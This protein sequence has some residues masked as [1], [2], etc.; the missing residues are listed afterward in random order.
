MED[1][2][3]FELI[4]I[5][6]YSFRVGSLVLIIVILISAR[7]L[8]WLISTLLKKRLRPL[9]SVD[10]GRRYA[11]TNIAKYFIYTLAVMLVLETAG[12]N[13]TVLI[14]G[15]T[16]LFV[17][18]GFGLQ[19]TFNDFISG[20]ILLFEGSLEIDH[21][22]E[23]KGVVGRVT[24][25]G[26]RTSTIRTR[27][28]VNIIVPN[29][30]FVSDN[31]VNWSHQNELTRFRLAISVAYGS[32]VRRVKETLLS[33]AKL[34]SDVHSNPAPLVFFQ[35]FAD[36]GLDFE[37]LFWTRKT[38]LAEKI[39]SDLRFDIDREFRALEI[40]IPFPQRDVHLKGGPKN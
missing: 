12:V 22:V 21:V 11:I 37:L 34:H 2:W 20:I 30:K 35:D 13:V 8:V 15:S 4:P 9:R 28:D 33:V 7:T 29:S 23:L 36:S 26:L 39:L 25:I 5:G 27:E 17:G 14:A 38:F 24:R 31:V 16:A 10:L 32:D 1:F 3:E 6:D 40:T 18:L 19:N